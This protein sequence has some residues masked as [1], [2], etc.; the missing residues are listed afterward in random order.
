MTATAHP[1]LKALDIEDLKSYDPCPVWEVNDRRWPMPV[2]LGLRGNDD[3]NVVSLD[4]SEHPNGMIQGRDGSGK[5]TLVRELILGLC[6]Q[7]GPRTVNFVLADFKGAAVFS[8]ISE[9]PHV[10]AGYEYLDDDPDRFA[11][12]IDGISEEITQREERLAQEG[13]KRLA[14]ETPSGD[15]QIDVDAGTELPPRLVVILEEPNEF[16][17]RGTAQSGDADQ[18]PVQRRDSAELRALAD[19][20]RR[21]HR[22]GV[23]LIISAGYVSPALYLP[24]RS[25]FNFGLSL[26]TTNQHYSKFVVG[27]PDAADLGEGEGLLRVSGPSG[28]AVSRFQGFN[29]DH[30][31]TNLTVRLAQSAVSQG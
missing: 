19:I 24:M 23:H 10:K 1:W 25:D 13:S 14:W 9:L 29:V 27:E 2:P 26:A 6:A 28:T 5:T 30:D 22:V 7:Y 15:G 16:L 8:G 31:D 3:T 12:M 18:E 11:E 21:G 4:L 20:A 17:L